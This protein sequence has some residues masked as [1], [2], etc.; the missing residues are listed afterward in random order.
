MGERWLKEPLDE[1]DDRPEHG[2][3]GGGHVDSAI[4]HHRIHRVK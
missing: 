2:E 1:I 4:V 3:D